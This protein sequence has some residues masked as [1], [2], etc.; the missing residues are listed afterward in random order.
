VNVRTGGGNIKIAIAK[1][2]LNAESG[3]G[4][5]S[6]SP[7]CRERQWRLAL[8]TSRWNVVRARFEPQRRRQRGSRDIGA[9]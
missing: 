7:A 3:G 9:P 5:G 2:K 4:S 1:G 6:M 8:A